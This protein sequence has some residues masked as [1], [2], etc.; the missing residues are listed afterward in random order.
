MK[1]IEYF[2]LE[3]IS[4][5]IHV[6]AGIISGYISFLINNSIISF[7]T[8]IIILIITIFF[9]KI[10]FKVQKDKKW[11]LGNGIILYLFIWFITWTILYNIA[12]R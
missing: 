7:F 2:D 10:A 12:I 9:V 8:M 1:L 4:S 6:I 11:W 3:I 5:I